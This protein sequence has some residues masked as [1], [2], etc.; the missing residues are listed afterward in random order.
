MKF[1]NFNTYSERKSLTPEQ[2]AF[3]IG[4][5]RHSFLGKEIYIGLISKNFANTNENRIAL[6]LPIE[7]KC[8][9]G[10]IY[11][12]QVFTIDGIEKPSELESFN[13]KHFGFYQTAEQ[14]ISEVRYCYGASTEEELKNKR[15]NYAQ[16]IFSMENKEK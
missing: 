14:A 3:L 1:F 4:C 11:N 15:M 2:M 16:K 13:G 5:E 12:Y 7:F 6:I 8:A 9:T 10:K